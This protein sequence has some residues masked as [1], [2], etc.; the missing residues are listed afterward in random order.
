MAQF[1][2]TIIQTTDK[3]VEVSGIKYVIS[4]TDPMSK[5][6]KSYAAPSMFDLIQKTG[7]FISDKTWA[8]IEVSLSRDSAWKGSI[9]G[10]E[11]T[12]GSFFARN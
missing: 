11:S 3:G 8:E 5:N 10:D 9:E 7:S 4:I 2:S 6:R 1:P 12:V